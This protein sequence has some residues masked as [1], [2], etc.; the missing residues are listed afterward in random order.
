MYDGSFIRWKFGPCS[1]SQRYKSYKKYTERCCISQGKHTLSCYNTVKPEGWKKGHLELQG[2]Q[3]CDDFMN[4][5]AMQKIHVQG[6]FYGL[7]S[8]ILEL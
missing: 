6:M 4:F 3:Y 1:S 5:K 2:R 8:I 7:I